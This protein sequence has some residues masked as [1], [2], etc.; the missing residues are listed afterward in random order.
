MK[1]HYTDT[2]TGIATGKASEHKQ[3]LL[4]NNKEFGKRERTEI[5]A[6]IAKIRATLQHYRKGKTKMFRKNKSFSF[7]NK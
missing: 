1:R 7:T 4:F 2:G 6:N 5:P 3:K